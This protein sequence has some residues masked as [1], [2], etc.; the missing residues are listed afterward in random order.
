MPMRTTISLLLFIASLAIAA[1]LSAQTSK[2][3][4]VYNAQGDLLTPLNA[5]SQCPNPEGSNGVAVSC[6]GVAV[7]NN[8]DYSLRMSSTDLAGGGSFIFVANHYRFI[9]ANSKPGVTEDTYVLLN[10]KRRA[11]GVVV[12]STNSGLDINT[13]S[14][15]TV[16]AIAEVHKLPQG[17]RGTAGAILCES[18]Q[19]VDVDG[20]NHVMGNGKADNAATDN[21]S[22]RQRESVR[23]EQNKL[24]DTEQG[25]LEKLAAIA[26]QHGDDP[27]VGEYLRKNVTQA[28]SEPDYL[29]EVVDRVFSHV[30]NVQAGGVSEGV[31]FLDSDRYVLYPNDTAN[32]TTARSLNPQDFFAYTWNGV[33]S[34]LSTAS[35]THSD[36]GDFLVCATGEFSGSS[37][38][39]TDCIRLLVKDSVEAIATYSETR[40]PEGAVVNLSGEYSV[41]ATSYQW[42]GDAGIAN[43][44]VSDTT[45]TAPAVPGMY[46]LT[47][48]INNGEDSDS[49][50]IEVFDI[51]PVAIAQ[52]NKEFIYLVDNVGD[53]A[54]TILFQSA[55]ISTDGTP[56]DSLLWQV[57]EQP[58]GASPTI[59][60]ANTENFTFVSD[61]AGLYRVRL[62]AT[63]DG[64]THAT[65]LLVQ[66]RER[67]APAANAGPDQT[68]F[69]DQQIILDGSL[70]YGGDSR[71][72]TQ[73]WSADGGSLTNPTALI[74]QFTSASMGNYLATLTV[75]DG[76]KTASDS[77]NITVKNRIPAASDAVVANVLNELLQGVL[78]AQDGDDDALT[79]SLVSDPE[80]GGVTIDPATGAFTYV[81]GGDKGCRYSPYARPHINDQGG[82]DV[83]VIK[84]CADNYVVAP[85]E[86]VNLT[87]SNSINATRLAGRT[88]IN[89]TPDS[90]DIRLAT[91]VSNDVG[92]HEVCVVGNIGASNNTSTACVEILVDGSATGGGPLDDGYVD[93]FQYQVTDGIDNSNVADICLTIGWENAKPVMSDVGV[94]VLEDSSVSGTFTAT[95][96]DGHP[97]TFNIGDNPSLGSVVINANTGDYTYTPAINEN[98]TDTFTVLIHDGF[99]FSLPATVTVNITPVND[100]PVSFYAG[101]IITDED[102]SMS[103]TLGG[104]D[105]DNDV[106]DFRLVVQGAKGDIVITDALTGTFTY[107]PHLDA[108]GSDSF[109]FVVND[110]TLDGN[111]K[112]VF[113]NI[114]PIND[115]P[116][117]NDVGP[118]SA[119]TDE[120]LVANLDG[121]DVDGDALIYSVISNPS[122]GTVVVS[123]ETGEFVFTSDGNQLGADSF[124]YRVSDGLLTSNVATA[125]INILVANTAPV[126]TSQ[127]ITVVVDTPFGGTLAGIDAETSPLTFVL[128]ENGRLG[129]ASITNA[130]NGEFE[131]T[132]S[133]AG[134][135]FFTFTANDGDKTSV[136]ANVTV[137]AISLAEFCAG[138]ESLPVDLDGDGYANYVELA[139]ATATNN[140]AVTPFGLDPV[141]LGVSFIDDDDSD[142]YDDF[143][144]LW[145]GSNHSSDTSLPSTSRLQSLPSCM[146]LAGDFQPP[147]MQAFNILTPVIDIDTAPTSSK[148]RFALTALDNAAGIAAVDVKLVSPS[149]AELETHVPVTGAPKVLYAEF[150]SS[151]FSR[152]AEAGVWAVAELSITDVRGHMLLLSQTDLQA[153]GFDNVLTVVNTLGDAAVPTL[154]LFDVL[155]P[156]VDLTTGDTVAQFRVDASDTPAGIGRINVRLESPSGENYRWAETTLSGNQNSVSVNIDTNVFD[157]Y[158]E[159][160]VW[161]VS[162]L[163]IADEAGNKRIY[164]TTDLTGSGYPVSVA[165]IS[166][167]DVTAPSLDL[168]E[169]IT[170]VVDPSPG[171]ILASYNITATDAKSGVRRV[172]VTLTSP[173]NFVLLGTFNALDN[174]ANLSTKIDSEF[175][176]RNAEPGVWTVTQVDVVD[177]SGNVASYSTNDLTGAGYETEVRVLHTCRCVPNHPP[178][179]TNMSITTDEDIAVSGTLLAT[180]ADG[181]ELTFSLV[182]NGG[183]GRVTIT[184]ATTGAF[185]YTPNEN[186]NGNDSFTFKADDGFNDSNIATV[187]V[188]I[189]PVADICT[190]RDQEIDVLY[191]TLFSGGLYGEDVDGD[192]ITYS[193]DT[194]GSLG[195]AV[196]TNVNTGAFNYTPNTDVVGDDSF[197]YTVNDGGLTSTPNTVI[198]HIKP[199][200]DIAEFTVLTPKVNNQDATVWLIAEARLATDNSE[201]ESA[202]VTLTGPS[203]QSIILL[204]NNLSLDA[205]TP[206]SMSAQVDPVAVNLEAGIW[207]LNNFRVKRR[208]TLANVLVAD[209][210]GAAGFADEVEVIG[211]ASP[212]ADDDTISTPLGVVH[213]GTLS[214]SDANGDALI[215]R[216]E[217]NGSPG[218][219]TL[220]NASTGDFSYTPHA[221]GVGSFSFQVNDGLTD[222]VTRGIVS[223]TVTDPGDGVP[224]ASGA[225][226]VVGRNIALISALIATD[227]NSDP[228]TYTVVTSPTHG[229]VNITNAATGDFNYYPDADYVGADSFTFRV[230]DGVTDSNIATVNLNVEIPNGVPV[231]VSDTITVLQNTSHNGNLLATDSDNDDLTYQLHSTG[232][233]GNV[234]VN[235]TTGA[236]AYTPNTDVLG[237]DYFTFSVSDGLS[238]SQQVT[239][240]VDIVSLQQVC[241]A[242]GIQAGFDADA[243]GWADVLERAFG[244]ATDDVNDTPAGLDPVAMGISFIDDDDADSYD[245]FHEVWLGSDKDDVDSVPAL[246]LAACFN[247]SFDGIKP[248]LLGFN[249][250]TPT[251]DLDGSDTSV[252]FDLT[253]LDNASGIRR[254]R[255]SLLSPSGVLVTKSVSYDPYPLLIGQ[256]I[257]T[258][259]LDDFAEAGNWTVAGLTLFDEAGNRLDLGTTELSDAGFSTEVIVSNSSG[260]ATGPSLDNFVVLTPTVYPGTAVDKMLFELTLSDAGA[261][262]SSARVDMVGPSG[263]IVSA[264]S[265]LATPL[266]NATLSMATPVLSDHL[267]QGVWN[268]LSVFVVD[269]AGN[270]VEY[271]DDLV[272]LGFATS[273]QS[274]N[275]QSDNTVPVMNSFSVLEAEVFPAT[276]DAKMRFSVNVS[277]DLAGVEEVRVDLRGPS[278]QILFAWGTYSSNYPLNDTAQVETS[279]LSNLLEQ[280]IWMIEKVIVFDEAGNSTE[281]T[282]S[283]LSDMGMGDRV[284]VSY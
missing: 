283:E 186:E 76:I 97:I 89:A 157:P 10:S 63:K 37:G 217:G 261:G 77:V 119:H 41:G 247:P 36:T 11:D 195:T 214:A 60:G 44:T 38:S 192:A 2:F 170:D 43:T 203:A 121:T 279:V 140:D 93:C 232:S 237:R 129:N 156:T 64:N 273:L 86:T 182:G 196:I 260:D 85:G 190:G 142:G 116:I 251:V 78:V 215:F 146:M 151:V 210:I 265:T 173:S 127:T 51:F 28:M 236:F 269:A 188:T 144:E 154:D 155:T 17:R 277:D 223:V 163:E 206:F 272:G 80:N 159:Q 147:A 34:I 12:D 21:E 16:H 88:W 167:L 123:P 32:L 262:V 194:N 94:T 7:D 282:T 117:A 284:L 71:S 108:N 202:R 66:V 242:G 33:D 141:A 30:A 124:T 171:D 56:V 274:T 136:V 213:F 126:A 113:I 235:A 225:T 172:V 224:V 91:F 148:A 228:L 27:A 8:G 254:A 199:E 184:N 263:V 233:L 153:R 74:S 83:P 73:S 35:F 90:G 139:F 111:L 183:L 135:D 160:G 191:N 20:L 72:I 264:V 198:V 245:D 57:V 62:T 99:E 42:S 13:V 259:P 22:R 104:L 145:L 105:Y 138:P 23:V 87:T 120:P 150:D 161:T 131:Y 240:W 67:G 168:F 54:E 26:V 133:S 267:E 179:A 49:F 40:V 246:W 278:G 181:H 249:I 176:A 95:D 92:L 143:V 152:Y 177:A 106:L 174:P 18:V 5:A 115:A 252:S 257:T 222:A 162:E 98:G 68:A 134:T 241:G 112:Q 255:V 165:V 276:G 239:V 50:T 59:S 180:D 1:P 118:I 234:V 102:T 6:Q 253:L 256:R 212:I 158:A 211:N 208:N 69:R 226:H 96:S 205:A 3:I 197:T 275:P 221:L 258:D 61:V 75:D 207:R 166:N 169:V 185:T 229:Q 266:A 47:L 130:A 15:A 218:V 31:L 19:G 238:S 244:T 103:G 100:V 79:Y 82:Q 29:T 58:A 280:G 53:V 200:F 227:P 70:S 107:N 271:V 187:S 281:T 231:P 25:D 219:V 45:W 84:L 125:N 132:A 101:S 55:S 270:S 189:N 149:G 122:K 9:A 137:N 204:A 14:E 81:P 175:F 110:Q 248:R 109:Y 114:N 178:L 4:Y 230:N 250:A 39:S 209:D 268:V 48:G 46:T 164:A 243:D 52:A 65:E 220:L 193:I 128:V 201:I 24:S 216:I